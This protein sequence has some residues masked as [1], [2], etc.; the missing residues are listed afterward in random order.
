MIN[1]KVEADNGSHLELKVDYTEGR[2]LM[3]VLSTHDI[4]MLASCGGLAL[5]GTCHVRF[6]KG[7]Q[8]LPSPD[9]NELLMLEM[10]PDAGADSRLSCQVKLTDDLNNAVIKVMPID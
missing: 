10:L 6:L 8:Y 9:E 1:I 3:E 7:G 5:C 2:S 4:G